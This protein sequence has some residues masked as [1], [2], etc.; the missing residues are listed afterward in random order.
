MFLLKFA[1]A[2]ELCE[3]LVYFGYG[4]QY[5]LSIHVLLLYSVDASSSDTLPLATPTLFV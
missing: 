3:H 1:L 4:R 2:A 5:F